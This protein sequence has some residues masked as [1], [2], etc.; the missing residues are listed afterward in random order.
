MARRRAIMA[1]PF[2]AGLARHAGHRGM[3]AIFSGRADEVTRAAPHLRDAINLRRVMNLMLL[4]LV[5]CVAMA[6]Y[7]TGYQA[8]AALA[9]LGMAAAPGWRGT[10]I[11]ALGIGYDPA[12]VW[13]SVFHG[14]LYVLPIFGVTALLG[15]LW[16][17]LFARLRKRSLVEGSLLTALLFT[18]ILPP[19]AP[20]WQV[21]IGVSFGV[22]VGKEIFGGTGKNFLNP[23]ITGLVF[24]S[25]AYPNEM[26]GDPLWTELGGYGGTTIFSTAAAAGTGAIAQA[27]I[28]WSQAFFGL[29]Q[30]TLGETSTLACLLG[31]ALLIASGVASW[32]VMVGV[33]VGTVATALVFNLI[34]GE[35]SP[36]FALPWYWHLTL[37]GFAFGAV[38]LATEPASAA[39]TDTGR[40]LYGLLIGFMIVLIRVANPIHPDG[41]ML[42]ILLGNI[43]APLIDYAVV[44][45]NIRRRAW[46]NV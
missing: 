20:L 28:T 15:G 3:A 33:L 23:A 44:W 16:E 24:L 26:A 17:W 35:A 38:F 43:F 5:P 25:L 7:N 39:M 37:G 40:W 14:L 12:S 9:Q 42:A 31:A 18:L 1:R 13:A 32:R 27:G 10:V 2:A 19:A 21:A 46:R 30:G 11:G 45:T 6:L 22:V 41:V 36:I 34:G 4:A 8:N 29:V